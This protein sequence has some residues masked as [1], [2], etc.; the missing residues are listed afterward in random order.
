MNFLFRKIDISTL[1]F[2]RIVFG[3]LAL[4]EMVHFM[5]DGSQFKCLTGGS[6]FNFTYYGFEWVKPLPPEAM[7]ALCYFMI[8]LSLLIIVGYFYRIS[9]FIYGLGYTYIYLIEKAY[10]LNHG[11][12]FAVLCF[13]MCVLPANRAFSV[14]ARLNPSIRTQLIPYWGVFLLQFS[15]GVVY[16]YG[17]I[18]K[19]NPDWLRGIP[20][21]YWLDGSAEDVPIIGHILELDWVAVLMSYG[22]LLLDLTAIFFLSNKRTRGIFLVFVIFFHAMN[23]LIFSIGIFPY[24]SVSLSLMYF[25]PDWTRRIAHRFF[26]NFV[27]AEA[28]LD[29]TDSTPSL[30]SRIW[31]KRLALSFIV[32]FCAYH[33]LFPLRHFL[34][35][36]PTDWTEEGHK[37]SWHMMLRTKK[38][39]GRFT[40]KIPSEDRVIKISTKKYLNKRQRKKLFTHPEMILQFAHFLRDKYQAEGYEDV[41]V[42]ANVKSKFNGR[43]YTNIV[44]REV[45]LAK[46]ACCQPMKHDDWIIIREDVYTYEHLKEKKEKQP[47]RKDDNEEN[48]SDSISI[49]SIN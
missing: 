37:Y 6:D 15:M 27:D 49:D 5:D 18:A 31:N 13:L 11:Y 41:E 2:F 16:F 46:I 29:T 17:G 22:G 10:Y 20:L 38:G 25:S 44:D 45:D 36:G 28:T 12:L 3:L 48:L 8:G 4:Y 47:I 39:K 19:L 23:K 14:D 43:S 32:I 24:L 9:A 7:Y 35:E 21:V 40:V 30:L 33:V 34:I 26:P 1:I 42:Y